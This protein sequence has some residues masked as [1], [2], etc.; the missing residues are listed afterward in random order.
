MGLVVRCP[1]K[2]EKADGREETGRHPRDEHL[3]GVS[4]F[5]DRKTRKL[6]RSDQL[7]YTGSVVF[8]MMTY[9]EGVEIDSIDS[10]RQHCTNRQW[11]KCKIGL[12]GVEA[13]H[14]RVHQRK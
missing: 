3:L 7:V 11:E 9:P 6:Y 1:P 12:Q 13:I 8:L 14:R 10:Q 2:D 4:L 5:V